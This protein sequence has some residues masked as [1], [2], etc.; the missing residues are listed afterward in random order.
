M[1]WR[2]LSKETNDP[3][4]DRTRRLLPETGHK[5]PEAASRGGDEGKLRYKQWRQEK[6]AP[7][8][9]NR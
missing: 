9:S 3:F 2:E 4:Y 7:E 1:E 5:F 8:S 6:E